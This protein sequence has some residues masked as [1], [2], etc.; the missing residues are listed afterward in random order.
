MS[1]IDQEVD[2]AISFLDASKVLAAEFH[3]MHRGNAAPGILLFANVTV[4]GRS[5]YLL[6]KYDEMNVLQFNVRGEG[7]EKRVAHIKGVE[8][9]IVEDDKALQ[10]SILFWGLSAEDSIYIHD[11]SNRNVA[12]FVRNWLHVSPYFTEEEA[13]EAI[14]K[15][16]K[17]TFNRPDVQA[18]EETHRSWKTN[19]F[20]IVEG[21]EEVDL[22]DEAG[23][24]AFLSRLMPRE[25][26]NEALL[27][28]VSDALRKEHVA[29]ET[30]KLSKGKLRR[31]SRRTLRTEEGITVN[32][33]QQDM[34]SGR[35]EVSKDPNGNQRITVVT[36]GE[37]FQRDVD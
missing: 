6:N 1:R 26:K 17:N 8:H 12:G 23:R 7:E 18:D 5:H 19:F 13:T 36:S 37:I 4:N 35:V 22:G 15:A 9:T 20:D 32:Y 31:P 33:S 3:D 10:K 28:M 14:H 30:T 16:L 11:R 24:A 27:G 29:D 25:T 21:R 34:D 2:D